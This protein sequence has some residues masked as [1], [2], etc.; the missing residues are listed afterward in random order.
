MHGYSVLMLIFGICIFLIGIYVYTG[1]Y[2]QILFARSHMKNPGK[3]YLK[4]L[5]KIILLVSTAPIISA[6]SGFFLSENSFIPMLILVILFE[7]EMYLGVK[8]FKK[9]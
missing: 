4:Y 9:Q 2:S 1:H 8:Y 7:V 6:I 5:G 3:E